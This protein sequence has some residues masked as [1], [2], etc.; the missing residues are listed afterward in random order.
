MRIVGMGLLVIMTSG[1]R[2]AQRFQ[3]SD[4]TVLVAAEVSVRGGVLV[5]AV[6][7]P[8]GQGTVERSYPLAQ[9]ARIDWPEPAELGEARRMLRTGD[10][11]GALAT[12]E[13][14]LKQFTPLAKVP[15]SWWMA[16]KRVSLHGLMALGEGAASAQAARELIAIATDP[17][18]VG[19]ARLALV[20]LEARTGRPEIARAMLATVAGDDAPSAVQGRAWLLR[21]DLA[22]ARGTADEAIEAYLQVPVFYGT[23][24]DLLPAA[25]LGSARAFRAHGDPTRSERAARELILNYP[26]SVEAAAAVHEFNL[27]SPAL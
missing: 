17:E 27:E 2:S 21:G 1:G 8:G 24:D 26:D 6:G 23:H 18:A 14:V 16:A 15:G 25:L 10:A 13:P 5:H 4:G 9:V 12:I 3:L 7:L 22:L 11:A 20:E 19:I